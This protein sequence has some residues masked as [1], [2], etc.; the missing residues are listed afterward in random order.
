MG[1]RLVRIFPPFTQEKLQ[2]LIDTEANLV[3]KNNSTYNGKILKL[4]GNKL[5][6]KDSIRRKHQFLVEE[7][8]EI[9]TD[10]KTTY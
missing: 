7:L 6:F 3:F 10:K 9:I 2:A 4:E 8:A 1:K 5:S